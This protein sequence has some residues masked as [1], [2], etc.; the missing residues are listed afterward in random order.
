MKQPTLA[1]LSALA[2]VA[3]AIAAPALRAAES[4]LKPGGTVSAFEPIHV[5]GPDKG[6]TTCPVCKYGAE[7]AA[8]V[9]I[10]PKESDDNVVALAKSLDGAIAKNGLTKFRAFFVFLPSGESD[11]AMAKKL[12]AIAAKAGTSKVAF[13][14]LNGTNKDAIEDYK[15]NTSSQ[16]RNTIMVYAN[17][18]VIA[19]YVN[20]QATSETLAKIQD[21]VKEAIAAREKTSN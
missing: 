13:T 17:R 8:Q 15:V 14:Y 7:A 5:T 10:S 19:N 18:A 6:T 16:I 2:L 3:T 4:G 9:W 12:S 21:S 11:S 20:A 1:A